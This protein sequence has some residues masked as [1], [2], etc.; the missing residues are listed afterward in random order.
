MS[1]MLERLEHIEQSVRAMQ[2]TDNELLNPETDIP[3]TPCGGDN[4]L[5]I[6]TTL[7]E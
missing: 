2:G 7:N 1:N 4:R 3:Q 5:A 6:E